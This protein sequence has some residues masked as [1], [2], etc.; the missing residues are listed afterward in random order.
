M[1]QMIG[2]S[3]GYNVRNFDKDPILANNPPPL[4]PKLPGKGLKIDTWAETY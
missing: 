4:Y 3:A 1:V 2:F